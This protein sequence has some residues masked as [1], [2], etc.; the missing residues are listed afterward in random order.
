VLSGVTSRQAA[1]E[2]SD[3]APVGIAED[4]HALLLGS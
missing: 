2:A 4:L 1:E 3:P